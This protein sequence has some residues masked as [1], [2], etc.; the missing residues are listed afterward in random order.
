[1]K[2][3]LKTIKALCLTCVI[4][5]NVTAQPN[6]VSPTQSITGAEY[7]AGLNQLPSGADLFINNEQE[8]K[9]VFPFHHPENI[10]PKLDEFGTNA[11]CIGIS[12]A[13]IGISG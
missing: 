9:I 5:F 13:C 11:W 8:I 3:Q 4:A 10:I 2:T 6:Q 7:K 12:F 1:M